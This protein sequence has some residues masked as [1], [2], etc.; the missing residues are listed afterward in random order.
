MEREEKICHFFISYVR[1]SVKEAK[2]I[3]EPAQSNYLQMSY[4]S[5]PSLLFPCCPNSHQDN[6]M[7][8]N[9]DLLML[10][11]TSNEVTCVFV[12]VHQ[13]KLCT[14]VRIP[15]VS[16]CVTVLAPM[17]Y[18]ETLLRVHAQASILLDEDRIFSEHWFWVWLMFSWSQVKPKGKVFKMLKN[19]SPLGE[20]NFA[21]RLSGRYI[22]RYAIQ[23]QS[24]CWERSI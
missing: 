23:T 4:I 6:L 17:V 9:T 24:P 10:Q 15:R 19:Y 20:S 8:W 21:S 2:F 7:M 12:R 5:H 3:G 16:V 1:Q 22:D 18:E 11:L 13:G 14:T